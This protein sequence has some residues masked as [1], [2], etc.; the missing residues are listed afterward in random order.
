MSKDTT[1][2]KGKSRERSRESSPAQVTKPKQPKKTPRQKDRDAQRSQNYREKKGSEVMED[3]TKQLKEKLHPGFLHIRDLVSNSGVVAVPAY[4]RLPISTR[5]IGFHIAHCIY[6][7]K[8]IYEAYPLEEKLIFSAYRIALAQLEYKIVQAH[9]EVS[10]NQCFDPPFMP[11]FFSADQQ[12][13]I[14]QFRLAF[15]GVANLI[16]TVGNV[17][18]NGCLYTPV[19]LNTGML[20][21]SETVPVEQTAGAA[22][23]VA[24]MVK[25]YAPEATAVL[26]SNLKDTVASLANRDTPLDARKTFYDANP[27][28]GAKWTGAQDPVLQNPEDFW[29]A[30]YDTQAMFRDVMSLRPFYSVLGTKTPKYMNGGL[31]DYSSPGASHLLVSGQPKAANLI[32]DLVSGT[33]STYWSVHPVGNI[34]FFMGTSLATGELPALSAYKTELYSVRSPTVRAETAETNIAVNIGSL[35]G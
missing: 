18:F 16:N 20:E 21:Y 2:P 13:I 6:N 32:G 7:F 9:S 28:P 19:Y 29:P 15:T 26:F 17:S 22:T 35:Y 34:S 23:T 11:H 1:K 10:A 25:L 3:L 24:R 31:V 8:R 33:T 5:G 30:D 12:N 14:C 27:L 4:T